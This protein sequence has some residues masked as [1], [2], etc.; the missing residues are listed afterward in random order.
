MPPKVKHSKSCMAKSSGP[1]TEEGLRTRSA[2][3]KTHSGSLYVHCHG[4]LMLILRLTFGAEKLPNPQ[5]NN[6]EATTPAR[7]DNDAESAAPDA[8]A[9]V[10][11]PHLVPRD[12]GNIDSRKDKPKGLAWP[13]GMLDSKTPTTR[14][15]HE[16]QRI[17]QI[18]SPTPHLTVMVA[19]LNGHSLLHITALAPLSVV[20]HL[21]ALAPLSV[22]VCLTALAPLNINVRLRLN[23]ITPHIGLLITWPLHPDRSG[24]ALMMMLIATNSK[25]QSTHAIGCR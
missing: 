24:V 11:D 14:T 7:R 10:V 23:T 6:A 13:E 25:K 3:M 18:V 22:V 19:P 12:E 15:A 8:E 5:P 4:F 17:E 1:A 2:S 21:A 9:E 16:M 20:I